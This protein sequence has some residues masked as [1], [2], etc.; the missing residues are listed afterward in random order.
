MLLMCLIVISIWVYIY[1]RY[2]CL[3][4]VCEGCLHIITLVSFLLLELLPKSL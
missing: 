2:L 3:Y 4:Q 1:L